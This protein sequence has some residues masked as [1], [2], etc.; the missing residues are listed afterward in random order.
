[1]LNGLAGAL[2]WLGG[3]F[4]DHGFPMLAGFFGGILGGVA[5][6]RYEV[7]RKSAKKEEG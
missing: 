2:A 6:Q 3:F 5:S 1:M 7:R 4:S